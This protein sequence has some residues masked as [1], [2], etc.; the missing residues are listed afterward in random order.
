MSV[1]LGVSTS[2]WIPIIEG[3]QTG[4]EKVEA[5]FACILNSLSDLHNFTVIESVHPHQGRESWAG[6]HC[7]IV[8]RLSTFVDVST[9]CDVLVN[10][11][12]CNL[13]ELANALLL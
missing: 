8:V 7:D 5:R 4:A 12:T 13:N 3:A 9:N 10:C 2:A 1:S 11:H 6:S